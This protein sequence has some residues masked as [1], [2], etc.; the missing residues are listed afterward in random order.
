MRQGPH[1]GAQ[2]STTN[3][4]SLFAN[5]ALKAASPK[6][7][8]CAVNKGA[9]H[10]PQQIG[11]GTRLRVVF[12][13]GQEH[14]FHIYEFASLARVCARTSV[15][16]AMASGEEYSSGRWLTPA[17]QGMKSIAAGQ[18]RDMNRES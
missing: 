7:S 9:L 4:K 2:K 10:L 12:D 11:K 5:W 16:W 6:L 3:G 8:G 15:P 14:R 17:R 13:F 1:Q 18:M